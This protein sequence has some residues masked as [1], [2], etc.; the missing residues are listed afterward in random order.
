MSARNLNTPPF[1]RERIGKD[2]GQGKR[3]LDAAKDEQ[4]D[5]RRHAK[6]DGSADGAESAIHVDA[7]HGRRMH[8]HRRLVTGR[9]SAFIE[10]SRKKGALVQAGDVIGDKTRG[11][12]AV[13]ED[14]H[15]DL[16]AVGVAGERELNAEFRGAIETIRI[17]RKKNVGHVATDER[18]DASESLLALAAGGALALVVYADEI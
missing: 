14:F 18:L 12:E 2:R 8:G 4:R 1:S 10:R 16:A 11:A 3:R 13:I 7:G 6:A 5:F 17:V 9:G 15:L